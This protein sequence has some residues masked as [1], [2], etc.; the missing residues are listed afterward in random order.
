MN[1][2]FPLLGGLMLFAASCTAPSKSK[3]NNMDNTPSIS[4]Q[5]YGDV[6]GQQV[7]QC[8]LKNSRGM[9]VRILNY[10]GT[11]TDILVPDGEGKAANMILG[12]DSL[13]GYRQPGNP[14]FGCLVGRY[15]NRIARGRFILD[16]K[17]YVLAGN[18]NGN[19]LHGGLQGFDK[20]IWQMKFAEGDSSLEL[21]YTS[22]DGEEGYPGNLQVKVV[23]TLT[24]NNE[25][26]I[27]YTATTDKATPVNL[28]N[29]CYFNLS[30][31][32]DNTI[33]EHELELAASRFT[34]VDAQLIPTGQ[35][36]GVSGTPMDFTRPKR[37]GR[38][39]D[40]VPGG[41][42]HNFVLDTGTAALRRAAKL[43]H[44][45][46]GRWME[47]W[48]TAPGIQFYSGNF[49]DGTLKYTRSGAPYAKH[50]GLCLETQHFPDAP[51]QPGFPNTVLRPGE[52]YRQTSIYKFGVD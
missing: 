8:T 36:P 46:S 52:T 37:I 17:E 48:T 42:D 29:H 11:V 16:G 33:L 12:Y 43:Y 3:N 47:V 30:G 39:I 35:L 23:Y 22:K 27:D 19:A 34:A 14:Y 10:G 4:S 5:P 45:G 13:A 25:L 31:G 9:E 1:L 15:A 24:G 38:D 49:L 32:K 6:D 2:F 50:A 7:L 20:K 40:Q 18:N 44:P 21:R 26:Y 51:N 41:F 28:S